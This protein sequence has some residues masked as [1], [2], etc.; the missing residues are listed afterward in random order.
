MVGGAYDGDFS[1]AGDSCTNR[2]SVSDPTPE[3]ILCDRDLCAEGLR[4]SAAA[5]CCTAQQ[6]DARTAPGDT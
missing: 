6:T 4:R 1:R 3:T 5:R 2:D